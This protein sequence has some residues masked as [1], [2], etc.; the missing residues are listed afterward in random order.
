MARDPDKQLLESVATRRARLH[1]AFLHGGLGAR[2]T[3][4]DNVR[5]FVVSL[6]LASVACAGC[7]GYS[8]LRANGTLPSSQ[9]STE[10]G[11]P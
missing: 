11:T 3:T 5:R 2:R 4:S 6:V 1:A 10:Q 9:T 8:F 7:V